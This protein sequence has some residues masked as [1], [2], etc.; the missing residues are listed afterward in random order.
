M[1]GRVVAKGRTS[2]G[3]PY[4]HLETADDSIRVVVPTSVWDHAELGATLSVPI[5]DPTHPDAQLYFKLEW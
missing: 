5:D 3:A 1:D 4:V 2:E